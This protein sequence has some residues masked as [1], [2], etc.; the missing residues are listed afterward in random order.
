MDAR[1][2]LDA[3]RH[4]Q[5]LNGIDFVEIASADQTELR[6]H[7]HNGVQLQGTLDGTTPAA[8]T[9]GETIPTI[10]V[11]PIASG[12]WSTDAERRPLLTL[13]VEAPGDF[14]LYT[15]TL[16]SPR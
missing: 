4:S 2:R 11:L 9:G 6:V 13:R 3:L 7:F 10:V 15:M 14:S 5:S 8:I 12:D 1:D 16:F